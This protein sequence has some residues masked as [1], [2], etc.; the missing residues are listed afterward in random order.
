MS[1]HNP[2]IPA[3]HG[4]NTTMITTLSGLCGGMYKTFAIT[5]LLM[6]VTMDGAFTVIVYAVL[7]AAAG[8]VTK[9][10]FDLIKKRL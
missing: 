9:S 8:Y 1:L 5:P 6:T 2:I 7:S 3:Q 10:L 4:D